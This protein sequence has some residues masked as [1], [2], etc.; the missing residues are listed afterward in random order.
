MPWYYYSGAK[1]VAIPVGDGEVVSV[2][3][4]TKVEIQP[5]SANDVQIRTLS[6]MGTLRACGRPPEAPERAKVD[7]KVPPPPGSVPGE[8][9]R[10]HEFLIKEGSTRRS[11]P[12]PFEKIAPVD[13]A[14][15]LAKDDGASV[16]RFADSGGSGVKEG[17]SQSGDSRSSRR[18]KRRGSTS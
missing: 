7:G 12:M 3:P 14:G 6:K 13:R 15:P 8:P 9:F 18:S 5:S 2:R 1:P 16:E 4:H 11:A 10:F 17:G